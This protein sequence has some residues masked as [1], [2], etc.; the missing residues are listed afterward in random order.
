[1][2]LNWIAV[3]LFAGSSAVLAIWY[4]QDLFGPW[5][6]TLFSGKNAD[7]RTAELLRQRT[8]H[9]NSTRRQTRYTREDELSFTLRNIVDHTSAVAILLTCN[10]GHVKDCAVDSEMP[11]QIQPT[12]FSVGDEVQILFS[13]STSFEKISIPVTFQ[14]PSEKSKSVVVTVDKLEQLVFV[15]ERQERD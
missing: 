12:E 6:N 14:T 15:A 2:Q 10:S 5:I 1:M 4:L 11:I 13:G 8:R 7:E 3:A 9:N